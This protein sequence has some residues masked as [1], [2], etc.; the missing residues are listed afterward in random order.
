MSS[1]LRTGAAPGVCLY[2]T[3]TNKHTIIKLEGLW[4]PQDSK[5][6]FFSR[7]KNLNWEHK[8][9]SE[10]VEVERAGAASIALQPRA[11]LLLCVRVAQTHNCCKASVVSLWGQGPPFLVPA[12]AVPAESRCVIPP[13]GCQLPLTD[14]SH[15]QPAVTF[16]VLGGY[17]PCSLSSR[18]SLAGLDFSTFFCSVSS[19]IHPPWS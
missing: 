12:A 11:V 1:A 18:L 15:P 7:L 8:W 19:P 2:P 10:R 17:F 6:D 9:F 16:T 13:P 3:R 5:T 4:D 14:A